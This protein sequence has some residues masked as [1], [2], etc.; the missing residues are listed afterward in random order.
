MTNAAN[1]DARLDQDRIS[2]LQVEC[3]PVGQGLTQCVVTGFAFAERSKSF[4]GR[5]VA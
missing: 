5:R 4:R 2:T 1:S 3:L